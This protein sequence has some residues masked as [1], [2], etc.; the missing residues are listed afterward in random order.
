MKQ[1]IKTQLESAGITF[2]AMF[3]MTFCFEISQPDFV[4]SQASLFALAS[5]AIIAGVRA[6][7]K[8]IYELAKDLMKKPE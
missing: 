6:T 3:L 1:K 7:A 8:I 5:S 2:V 4:L